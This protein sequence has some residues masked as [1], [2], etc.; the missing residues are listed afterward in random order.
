MGAISSKRI[1]RI[2]FEGS[3]NKKDPKWRSVFKVDTL[4]VKIVKNL[5]LNV[6]KA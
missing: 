1:G 4:Y 6:V 5:P 2:E 3:E